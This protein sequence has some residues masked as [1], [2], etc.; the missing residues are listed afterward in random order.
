MEENADAV[1]EPE[2]TEPAEP[3]PA[4]A[5][6]EPA[7]APVEPAQSLRRRLRRLLCPRRPPSEEAARPEARTRPNPR[8]VCRHRGHRLPSAKSLRKLNLRRQLQFQNRSS[9]SE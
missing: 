4:E 2:P 7:P 9:Q 3:A 6:A 8:K 1:P 5:P